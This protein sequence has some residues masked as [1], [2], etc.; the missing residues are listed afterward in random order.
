ME[1][2]F[3]KGLNVFLAP[4]EIAKPF[5]KKLKAPKG[6]SVL[7]EKT[8]LGM[9]KQ[10]LSKKENLIIYSHNKEIIN[11]ANGLHCIGK[12]EIVSLRV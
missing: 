6:Y 1:I 11:L 3:V 8:K 9:I 10:K 7:G 5:M 12:K 2:K 4:K